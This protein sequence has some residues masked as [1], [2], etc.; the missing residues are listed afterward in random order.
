MSAAVNVATVNLWGN[1]VGAV[2]LDEFNNGIF[3]FDPEFLKTDLDIAPV[4]MPL[5]KARQDP[6]HSFPG[7]RSETFKRL[8]GTL[9]DSLPDKFG[10]ALVDTWLARQGRG[11]EDF[12]II[13]RLCYTGTRA[14]GAL[15]FQ[16][17]STGNLEK[18]VDINLDQMV[19]L[20]REVFKHRDRLDHTPTNDDAV[21]QDA[22]LNI[23]IVGTSAGGARA[24]AVIA[25]DEKT[26]QVMS[27][28]A[29]APPPPA[30]AVRVG[31]VQS[32]TGDDRRLQP[33][34]GF[35]HRGYPRRLVAVRPPHPAQRLRR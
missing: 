2:A 27:G 26:G 29:D 17:S 19:S 6:R 12:S 33:V 24:K 35:R 21:N 8:P 7:L 28:Q 4:T 10:Q 32:R 3:E 13:E 22:L 18:A 5:E 20:V 1:R 25:Y 15:E 31:R 14:M 9:A 11:P 30:E 16:P 34:A 23:L